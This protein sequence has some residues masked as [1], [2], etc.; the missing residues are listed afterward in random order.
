[1][2]NNQLS[3]PFAPQIP[4]FLVKRKKKILARYSGNYVHEETDR[5]IIA[6]IYMGKTVDKIAADLNIGTKHIWKALYR[7]GIKRIGPIKKRQEQELVKNI[8][9]IYKLGKMRYKDVAKTLIISENKVAYLFRKYK[10]PYKIIPTVHSKEHY[11]KI[12]GWNKGLT[13]SDTVRIGSLARHRN[14]NKEWLLA[15]DD[16]PKISYLTRLLKQSG[17][18]GGYNLR[19]YKF[20]GK[21][22]EEY[23]EKF[24]NDEYFNKIYKVWLETGDNLMKPSIDHIVPI[25]K[26]GTNDIDNLQM[27]TLFENCAKGSMPLEEW[28]AAKSHIHDYLT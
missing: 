2:Q 27:L 6:G 5:R 17:S 22:Y 1:M 23:I 14:V 13:V 21:E 7:K 26:G 15:F 3:L 11:K 18:I 25:A 24:Y 9:R 10:I 20:K 8:K 28:N 12:A 19:V 4:D 16:Y